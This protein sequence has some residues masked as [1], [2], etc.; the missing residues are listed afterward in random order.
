MS[1]AKTIRFRAIDRPYMYGWVANVGNLI[2]EVV[3]VDNC[4]GHW[5]TFFF[6]DGYI[7]CIGVEEA[8]KSYRI[9]KSEAMQ[10]AKDYLMGKLSYAHCPLAQSERYYA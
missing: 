5:T 9:S 1:L 2:A 3:R 10:F 8:K 4:D 6:R 7:V